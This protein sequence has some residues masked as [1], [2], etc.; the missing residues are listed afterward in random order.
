MPQFGRVRS[1]AATFGP[2]CRGRWSGMRREHPGW[3]PP[4]SRAPTRSTCRPVASPRAEGTTDGTRGVTALQ[5]CSEPPLPTICPAMAH[6]IPGDPRVR[7]PPSPVRTALVT[8]QSRRRQM[9][10]DSGECP[11]QR[12]C[13]GW[14]AITGLGGRGRLVGAGAGH[15]AARPL[16]VEPRHLGHLGLIYLAMLVFV[17]GALLSGKGLL[18]RERM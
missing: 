13:A 15:R 2:S 5:R 11:A 10:K 4:H 17:A 8:D 9:M 1:P 12:R 6:E 16:P 18:A 7:A 3:T 14:F